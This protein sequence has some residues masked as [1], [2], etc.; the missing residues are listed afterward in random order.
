MHPGYIAID[1]Q[2]AVE[3]MQVAAYLTDRGVQW[4]HADPRYSEL[5]P[6]EE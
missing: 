2:P 4:E 5:Y 3:L 6:G 1:I